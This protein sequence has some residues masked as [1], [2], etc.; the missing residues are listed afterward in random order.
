MLAKTFETFRLDHVPRQDNSRA[1]LL[2]KL[3]SFTKPGQHKS[4]IRETLTSSRVDSS[5]ELKIMSLSGVSN[6]GSWINPI[7]SYLA[8]GV[9]PANSD[10]AQRV[11]RNS[12][13]YTLVDGHLFRFGFSRPILMCVENTEARRIMSE[14]HEG[15]CGSHIG[16]RA[17]ILRI[18]RAGYFWPT[19]RKDCIEHVKHCDPCQRQ[20]D[21]HRA[22][23]EILHSIHPPWPFHTWGI[24]IVGPF[25]LAK[26]Q[27]KYLIVAVEYLTKW[28]E[29]EPMATIAASKVE[30]F[31]WKNLVCRFG[32][33]RRLISDNGTQ[34][35]SSQVRR[36]CQQLGILQC[37]SSIEHPQT[38]GQAEAA[39]KVILKALKRRVLAS[40]SPWPEE[41]PRILW[42]YH[43]TQQSTTHETPFSLVYETDALLPVEIGNPV[44][45]RK[46]LAS[47]LNE[48]GVRA[49]L[50]TLE[51]VR[52]LAR[53]TG[54]AVKQ[55]VE[56]RYRTKVIPRD[57]KVNN[58]VL[59][60]AHITEV[61][62]KLSPKWIGPFR[63]K[64]VLPGGA[65]RVGTLD[66]ATIPRTWNAANLRFY[67]S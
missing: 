52:E 26:R 40:K 16:G 57:F 41:I 54:E 50:D 29:A 24:D 64:E 7:R 56:R 45:N 33:P 10:E 65:Y 1:D 25:P 14:L 36:T 2:S 21:I 53:I 13:R 9:L 22:P 39:N 46:E 31:I 15:I 17:L 48:Q 67:F 55:R 12:S 27:L 3:A 35:T 5:S 30:K 43:T 20:G 37:F 42:A 63:I 38:N 4:V 18:L 51:E 59:R 32:V 58:L 60:R 62:H 19:M 34:F 66:G 47:D 61:E 49:N 23:P 6:S 11:K 8:D 44:E 28:I